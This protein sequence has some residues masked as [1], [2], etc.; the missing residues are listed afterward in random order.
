MTK[1]ILTAVALSLATSAILSHSQDLVP[2]RNQLPTAPQAQ[3]LTATIDPGRALNSGTLRSTYSS[4]SSLASI[5]QKPPASPVHTR[6]F[7]RKY[8]LLNGAQMG[9][10]ILDVD[11]TQHCIANGTCREAIPLCLRHRPAGSAS[12]LDSSPTAPRAATF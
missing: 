2:T 7:D 12:P 8:I 1:A 11:M 4:S 10:A 9:L 5:I 6:V 3:T